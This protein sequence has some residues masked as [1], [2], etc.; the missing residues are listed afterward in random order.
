MKSGRSAL[1]TSI[2]DHHEER[3]GLH[4]CRAKADAVSN[5]LSHRRHSNSTLAPGGT[6]TV[7][8][9][10]TSSAGPPRPLDC[11]RKAMLHPISSLSEAAMCRDPLA[12]PSCRRR[13]RLLEGATTAGVLLERSTGR[14]RPSCWR[15]AEARARQV[16]P[17]P[18]PGG[19]ARRPSSVAVVATRELGACWA[20][21]SS[22]S[23]SAP[24]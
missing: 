3:A 17:A 20:S 6:T 2:T 21:A 9:P 4:V 19:E 15:P 13:L 7:V 8:P 14:L 24:S 1:G 12:A 22:G 16:R 5:N 18:A 11:V 10:L 23:P